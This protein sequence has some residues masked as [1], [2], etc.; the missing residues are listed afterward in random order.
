MHYAALILRFRKCGSN[1]LFNAGKPIGADDK[2]ILYTAVF[3]SS[4]RTDSQYFELSF[5][6]TVIDST[7][8]IPS[9]FMPSIT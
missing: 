5:S 7:S 4:L 9:L 6:P 2:N 8:L 3:L 1:G